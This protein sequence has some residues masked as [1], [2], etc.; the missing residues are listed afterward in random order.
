MA[1]GTFSPPTIIIAHEILEVVHNFNNLGSN[2]S[3]SLS[4]EDEINSRIDKAA[5]TM[6]KLNKRVWQ[7][8]KLTDKT[9]LCV[10][11][12][13]VIS[14][15]R[16]GSET[17]TTYTSHEL[18]LN[19]F[20]FRCLRRILGIKWQDKVPNS[21]VLMRANIQSMFSILLKDA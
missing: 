3:N 4:I 20:H 19:S 7:N 9:K 10:Y 2:V 1:Q 11:R 21:E 8:T 18:K 12:A 6:A 14:T 16:Y 5:V 17:W 15:L 13:C